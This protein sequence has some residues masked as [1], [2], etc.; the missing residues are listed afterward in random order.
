MTPA[1]PLQAATA[2]V[3][4]A[5]DDLPQR[6]AVA[7][8]FDS[9][10]ASVSHVLHD[11]ATRAAMI[12]DPVLDFDAAAGRVST[13]SADVLSAYVAEHDLTVGWIVET[14]V[15]ADH[16][17]AATLLR[18]RLGG[19]IVMGAGVVEVRR[20]FADLY[21]R[22]AEGEAD[23]DVLLADGAR[24]ALGTLDGMAMHVPGHTPADTAFVVGDVVLTGDTLFMPD[25]GTA[26]ADFPG[27]DAHALYRSIRRLLSLP[28]ETRLLHCHDYPPEGRGPAW[29][30]TVAQQRA[31]NLH[32][33]GDRGEDEFVAMRQARDATLKMPALMLAA[34]QVNIDA[35]RLSPR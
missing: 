3:R 11:R 27:G 28:A 6:P 21:G 4:A 13:A 8:F 18:E 10:T 34:V 7:S 20:R 14:H 35:G 24:F 33:G 16:L 32:V 31:D 26:R 17:S 9:A 22:D 19:R 2:I 15:H 12:V 25:V 23:F 1:D 30:S 29:E 5:L